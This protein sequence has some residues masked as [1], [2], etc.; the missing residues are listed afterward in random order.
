M[1]A[2]RRTKLAVSAQTSF[3]TA[4]RQCCCRLVKRSTESG[5]H[6]EGGPV[7]WMP[8]P[9][10]SQAPVCAL[11]GGA[12]DKGDGR[13]TRRPAGLLIA[14]SMGVMGDVMNFFLF[15]IDN[16]LSLCYKSFRLTDGLH[17]RCS[18]H[19]QSGSVFSPLAQ[20]PSMIQVFS[21]LC[22]RRETRLL[23]PLTADLSIPQH[24]SVHSREGRRV[25][26]KVGSGKE[27]VQ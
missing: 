25:K 4:T 6:S 1:N 22:D 16:S 21:R 10:L 19:T 18:S 5:R 11:V 8:M 17:R 24:T 26:S 2:Q 20:R 23:R 9:T 27:G 13:I 15:E 3:G 7:N 12:Q 14:W